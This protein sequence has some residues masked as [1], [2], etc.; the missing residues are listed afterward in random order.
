MLSKKV[1]ECSFEQSSSI[2]INNVGI[3]ININIL[4]NR[5]GIEEALK[6]TIAQLQT[7]YTDLH[8]RLKLKLS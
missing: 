2:Q 1:G 4:N 3:N 6:D 5:V 7:T 8:E